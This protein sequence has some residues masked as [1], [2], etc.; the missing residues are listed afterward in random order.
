MTAPGIVQRGVAAR[1]EDSAPSWAASGRET[2]LHRARCRGLHDGVGRRPMRHRGTRKGGHAP[3]LRYFRSVQAGSWLRGA[4]PPPASIREPTLAR[5]GS[6]LTTA[7]GRSSNEVLYAGKFQIFTP[8]ASLTFFGAVRNAFGLQVL[9]AQ[10]TCS[11]QVTAA[12][13][14]PTAAAN[15]SGCASRDHDWMKS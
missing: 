5:R 8:L 9:H 2:A 13:L 15:L 12:A 3:R 4:A 1:L 6:V 7:R 14:K 11:H 10:S